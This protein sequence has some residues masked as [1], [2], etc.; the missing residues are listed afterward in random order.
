MDEETAL[1]WRTPPSWDSQMPLSSESSSC[2]SFFPSMEPQFWETWA[3]F[4]W[5]R[6]ALD[7][8]P[9]CTFS[10]AT[11]PLWISVTPR[12]S[13]QN[14]SK[15]CKWRQRHFLPGM[16]CAILPVLHIW[17]NRSFCWQW[18]PMTT[19]WPSV[20]HHSTWSPCPEISAWSWSLVAI[21]VLL[22]VLWFTCI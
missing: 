15:Y 3:W 18:W 5:F 4:P 2:C 19:L 10:S 7:S 12:P 13:R 22:Y 9:P 6:S 14:A 1:L 21:S 11:C 8:T 17:G 20:T 16:C